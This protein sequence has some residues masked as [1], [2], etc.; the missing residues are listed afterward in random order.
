MK[1]GSDERSE[2]EP[3]IRH[4]A[5][6]WAKEAGVEIASAEQLSFSAFKRWADQCGYSVYFTFWSSQDALDDAERWFDQE[7]GQAWRN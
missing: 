6:Q 7:L 3:A 1:D 5:H 2:A 4:L